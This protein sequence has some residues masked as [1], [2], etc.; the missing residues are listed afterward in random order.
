MTSLLPINLRCLITTFVIKSSTFKICNG[1]NHYFLQ[2]QLFFKSSFH[3]FF[4]CFIM[5]IMF[6]YYIKVYAFKGKMNKAENR[7]HHNCLLRCYCA[8]ASI[9]SFNLSYIF[10]KI[11][12]F[13]LCVKNILFLPTTVNIKSPY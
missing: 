11:S 4:F 13:R 6:F 3:S 2:K 7:W 8:F 10:I 1:N 12:R 9:K 5:K